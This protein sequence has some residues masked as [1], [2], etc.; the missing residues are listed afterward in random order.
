MAIVQESPKRNICGQPTLTSAQDVT[1]SDDGTTNDE[2]RNTFLRSSDAD[3]TKT[4]HKLDGPWA[5]V[6]TAGTRMGG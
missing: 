3:V 6:I 2:E 1:M 5:W 4:R